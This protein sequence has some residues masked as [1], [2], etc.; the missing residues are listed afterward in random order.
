[1]QSGTSVNL[2]SPWVDN[3]SVNL[4]SPWVDNEDAQAVEAFTERKANKKRE[5]EEENKREIARRLKQSMIPE[6]TG[7]GRGLIDPRNPF[8]RDGRPPLSPFQTGN[9]G[10]KQVTSHTPQGPNFQ[11]DF[12]FGGTSNSMSSDE[13]SWEQTDKAVTEAIA[14]YKAG[15]FSDNGASSTDKNTQGV[16][17][18]TTA[19]NKNT[20]AIA[21]LSSGLKL[22]MPTSSSSSGDD[23]IPPPPP[24]SS[25]DDWIPPI[26]KALEEYEGGKIQKYHQGGFVRGYKKGGEVP[27]ILQEGEYVIPRKLVN[28]G[29]PKRDGKP[30]ETKSFKDTQAGALFTGLGQ[31]GASAISSS[32]ANKWWGDKDKGDDNKPTFD[33]NRFNTLGLDSDVNMRSN[34]SRLSARFRSEN[35]ATQDYGQYLLEMEDYKNQKINEKFQKRMGYLRQGIGLVGTAA[36]NFAIQGLTLGASAAVDGARNLGGS[37]GI[38][39]QENVQAYQK[40]KADGL[41]VN[42]SQVATLNKKHRRAGTMPSYDDFKG[43]SDKNASRKAANRK[44]L[45][46]ANLFK[47]NKKGNQDSDSTGFFAR[48]FGTKEQRKAAKDAK[49]KDKNNKQQLV[50]FYTGSGYDTSREVSL[51]IDDLY[52]KNA[53]GPIP[54]MLTK[55]E[56]VIP[57][58]IASRIGYDN[59]NKMNTTGNFPIVDGKGGIDNV[60][61]VGMNPGDFVI[62][63]SSTDKLQRTNPNLM[64]FAA[65]NPDGFKRASKAYYNGGVVDSELTYPSQSMG[66]GSYGTRQSPELSPQPETGGS[67]STSGSSGG[68]VTN[69]INVNVTID[70]AG[71][72]ASTESNDTQGEASSYNNEKELSQ[73]IKAA[74]LDVIRQEKRVGGEL[75]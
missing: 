74:V 51:F 30:M 3:E 72:E 41:D 53:G 20:G 45:N 4:P 37:M 22:W 34:D 23:W 27:A 15:G 11:G 63:K 26:P 36:A 56:A 17:G 31:M 57:S 52:K 5:K 21:D 43:I 54:A 9:W 48:T 47:S 44:F 62:R 46:P 40:A 6:S 71:G 24:S 14:T 39:K 50:D 38:G 66:G 49:I 42:Y 61:P 28:G 70:K 68:A 19:T 32:L 8:S 25:G 29:D 33:T 65:Q 55:G 67:S 13:W 75:S 16:N 58:A 12:N 69:N 64:R 1:M 2:P 60:G 10:T 18:L 73:K 7:A 59:L 35:K